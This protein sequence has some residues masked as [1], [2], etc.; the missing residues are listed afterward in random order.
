MRCPGTD[1]TAKADL[2]LDNRRS[3]AL[4]SLPSNCSIRSQ[5][6]TVGIPSTKTILWP[7]VR[8]VNGARVFHLKINQNHFDLQVNQ[9]LQ[10]SENFPMLLALDNPSKYIMNGRG[11]SI[12]IHL[13]RLKTLTWYF[14]LSHYLL[15]SRFYLT[16][17]EIIFVAT[18]NEKYFNNQRK[19]GNK[20]I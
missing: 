11:E 13:M 3:V 1:V 9:Y 8:K 19:W 20:W 10:I 5:E 17:L 6:K 4:H 7:S 16:V 15:K 18:N 14:K 12:D 2:D